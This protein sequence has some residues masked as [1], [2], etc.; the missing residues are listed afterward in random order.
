MH[1]NTKPDIPKII[2]VGIPLL[3]ILWG[4]VFVLLSFIFKEFYI[5]KYGAF[6]F[7][8]ISIPTYGYLTIK[9]AAKIGA[10]VDESE[11]NVRSGGA[12]QKI[13][14]K[15]VTKYDLWV[16]GIFIFFFPLGVYIS[17]VFYGVKSEAISLYFKIAIPFVIIIEVLLR[18]FFLR[19]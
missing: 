12:N 8:L 7:F 1:S 6:A 18:K 3:L 17:Q 16:A 11:E 15:Y 10:V 5:S 4:M 14:K 9:N 2:F 13:L 19:K